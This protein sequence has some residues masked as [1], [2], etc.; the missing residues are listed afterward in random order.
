M[1]DLKGTVSVYY[2]L[3]NF[4][5]VVFLAP[6]YY[7]TTV[8]MWILSVMIKSMARNLLQRNWNLSVVLRHMRMSQNRKFSFHVDILPTPF[9][10]V[11]LTRSWR[12]CLFIFHFSLINTLFCRCNK[13]SQWQSRSGR[14]WY[15]V[16]RRSQAICG[17][18]IWGWYWALSV[19]VH[20]VITGSNHQNYP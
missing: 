20:I 6:P 13:T 4:Y 12:L 11:G 17:L 7:R 14:A 8:N 18:I 19:H 16:W 1:K 9:S 15:F 3:D 10:M 2:E 5:Q